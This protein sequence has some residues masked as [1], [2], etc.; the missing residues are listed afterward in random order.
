MMHPRFTLPR[1]MIG[2]A[3]LVA[4]VLVVTASGWHHHH[5]DA[6]AADSHGCGVCAAVLQAEGGT[7]I[8]APPAVAPLECVGMVWVAAAVDTSTPAAAESRARGPPTQA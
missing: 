8:V 5:E 4:Q 1:W 3:A 6:G 7:T 2:L